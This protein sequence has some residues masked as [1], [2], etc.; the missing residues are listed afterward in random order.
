MLWRRKL[1]IAILLHLWFKPSSFK[2]TFR[3]Q[4]IWPWRR[5]KAG[6]R[7]RRSDARWPPAFHHLWTWKFRIKTHKS[8][9]KLNTGDDLGRYCLLSFVIVT[10]FCYYYVSMERNI[11]V[12]RKFFI[13]QAHMK[14]LTTMGLF[15]P[16]VLQNMMAY[17]KI[18][19]T[20]YIIETF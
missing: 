13:L 8:K 15:Y 16:T 5:S 6:C 2:L 17:S 18:L 11:G 1:W 4:Q 14:W 19:C 10:F 20:K 3:R 12:V 7:P 9:T